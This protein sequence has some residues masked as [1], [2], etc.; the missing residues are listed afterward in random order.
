M[1]WVVAFLCVL[2]L[3]N[4]TSY[5][6]SLPTPIYDK[7]VLAEIPVQNMSLIAYPLGDKNKRP[8]L[9]HLP[10]TPRIP[11]STQKLITTAVALDVLGADFVWRTDVYHTGVL[12]NG[13]VYG[14]VVFVGSG[15]P[16]MDYARL[17]KLIA[18]LSQKVRHITGNVYIDDGK[19]AGVAYDSYGFDGEGL[20]PYNASP[21]A[22]LVNFGTIETRFVP[23]GWQTDTAFVP[24]PEAKVA[25][26]QLLPKLDGVDFP[27]EVAVGQGCA[28]PKVHLKQN[29]TL[30]G[31]FGAECG[32]QSLW[33]TFGDNRLLAQKAVAGALQSFQVKLDGQVRIGKPAGKSHLLPLVSGLSKPVS[34]QIWQINQFSNNV[35]T[36]QVA[37]SLPLYAENRAVSSYPLAFDFLNRWWDKVGK[38]KPIITRASGLCNDC[39]IRP[40]AMVAL[41]DFMHRHQDFETYRASLPVA[42]VSGT[43]KGLAKRDGANPA[44]GR[45]WIKTGRLN[46]VNAMAGYVQGTSGTLY[47]VMGVINHTDA[48]Q[49]AK[50][51]AV[52][53]VFL[54]YVAER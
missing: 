27:K 47:A 38:D 14:D 30:T 46:H 1:A 3:Q 18:E 32:T 48:G 36:E 35:M 31:A 44:I 7:A 5:A 52:L 13:V 29:L 53:D 19:F 8:L 24:N 33:Q 4:F 54:A 6:Q 37:L 21:S 28:L 42:G 45:A 12:A 22:F 43:M 39:Q 11:A 20:R 9:A 15:D 41:L 16:S 25:T 10:D 17:D 2:F 26:V 49:N 23:S 40:S 34:E 50:A 51:T